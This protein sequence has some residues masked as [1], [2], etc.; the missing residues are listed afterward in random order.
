[1]VSISEII[2]LRMIVNLGL[3]GTCN[4]GS[5]LLCEIVDNVNEVD[6][7]LKCTV[8]KGDGICGKRY[9]RQPTRKAV[10]AELQGK[11][12]SV[13]RAERAKDLMR[14]G[15]P[16][17]PNLRSANVLNVSKNEYVTATYLDPNP[18]IALAK[19][20]ITSYKN[21]IHLV[22]LH[23]FSSYYWSNHQLH[24]FREYSRSEPVCIFIDA[25]G[26]IVKKVLR[27]DGKTKSKHIF[28]YECVV[29]WDG[30]GQF[31]VAQMLTEN[32]KTT[33]IQAWLNEWLN[34]GIVTPHFS[35][36]LN[37]IK[38]TT[39]KCVNL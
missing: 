36:L 11:A 22:A 37:R 33:S 8:E 30:R 5:V 4:C 2:G 25:T 16:E 34:A 18:V 20:Q 27:C 7:R 15:D 6:I 17:P 31:S 26:S 29:R 39:C 10:A 28:L 32:H 19:M 23:P 1:V 3:N 14:P 38:Q 21:M 9:L 35:K 13:Y 24:V 12:V